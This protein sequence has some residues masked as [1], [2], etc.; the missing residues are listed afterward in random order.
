[1]EGKSFLST[2]IWGISVGMGAHIGWEIIGIALRF[3]ASAVG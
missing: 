2:V 3:L 1:M